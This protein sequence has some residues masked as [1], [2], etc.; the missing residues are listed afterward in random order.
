ML[1]GW[2]A[3]VGVGCAH[4]VVGERLDRAREQVVGRVRVVPGR[5]T[6]VLWPQVAAAIPAREITST[7]RTVPVLVS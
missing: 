4:A 3:G 1:V 6:G 5:R 2:R 7:P